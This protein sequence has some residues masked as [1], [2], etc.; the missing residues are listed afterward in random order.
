MKCP[1]CDKEMELGVIS[2]PQ[3]LSWIKGEKKP[4]FAKA[5]FHDG[6]VVL[7]EVSFMKGSAVTA[8][9]C[10]DCEK[11]IIDYSRKSSEV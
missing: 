9:L 3:E 5:E 1:Y 2:S 8:Y 4:F 10:R 6:A 11:V 7:S